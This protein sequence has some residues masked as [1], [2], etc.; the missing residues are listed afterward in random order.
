MAAFLQSTPCQPRPSA[1]E[2]IEWLQLS[3]GAQKAPAW[4]FWVGD[5]DVPVVFPITD[6]GKIK[7]NEMADLGNRLVG[8][9]R[10]GTKLDDEVS[11]VSNNVSCT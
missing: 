10:E 1:S 6:S 9:Y 11:E 3:F 7:R 5:G 8:K 2:I 4:I